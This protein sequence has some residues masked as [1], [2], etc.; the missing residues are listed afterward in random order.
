MFAGGGNDTVLGGAGRDRLR[1]GRCDDVINARGDGGDP[2]EVV[3]GP[4]DDAVLLGRNDRIMVD[5]DDGCEHVRR[6]GG[7]RACDS[8][9]GG[10]D[11]SEV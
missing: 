7:P 2:D 6:P 10:R 8:H 1:G 9:N 5:E 3:C 11:E 4:G